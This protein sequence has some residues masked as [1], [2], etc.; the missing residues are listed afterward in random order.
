M[1]FLNVVLFVVIFQQTCS[2]STRNNTDYTFYD[3]EKFS[4][5]QSERVVTL[6]GTTLMKKYPNFE[7]DQTLPLTELLEWDLWP[8]YIS[9]HGL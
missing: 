9:I 2:Y 4:K 7:K 5:T 8:A 3:F 6:L 1:V